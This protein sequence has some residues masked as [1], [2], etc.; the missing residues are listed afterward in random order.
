MRTHS[1]PQFA[2]RGLVFAIA[3]FFATALLIELS[4]SVAL[5]GPLLIIAQTV[6]VFVLFP[7]LATGGFVTNMAEQQTKGIPFT[8]DK[9]LRALLEPLLGGS[10]RDIVFGYCDSPTANA[11]AFDPLFGGK[12][13]IAITSALR[14]RASSEQLLAIGAH[15]IAHFRHGD[16]R[17]KWYLLAFHHMMSTW[18]RLFAMVSDVA[19]RT[20]LPVGAFFAVL[21]GLVMLWARGPSAMLSFLLSLV[22]AKLILYVVSAV[23]LIWAGRL[24]D[25]KLHARFCDYSREREFAADATAAKMTSP[26]IMISALEQLDNPGNVVGIFDT[27]PPLQ[28]RKARLRKM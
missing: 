25:R 16:A 19:L 21:V 4:K 27:H 11:Y 8:E 22:T 1:Y 9:G 15:E 10:E 6:S 24:L 7:L 3:V 5:P 12:K 14:D 17:N 28:E 20:A 23:A 13:I 18:P 2:R 26:I